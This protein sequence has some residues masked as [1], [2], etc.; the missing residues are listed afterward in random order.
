MHDRTG[1]LAK[2]RF[3]KNSVHNRYEPLQRLFRV[4]IG[5]FTTRKQAAV[6]RREIMMKYPREYSEAWVNYIAK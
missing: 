1:Q 2:E 5:K 3:S 6:S 4:S